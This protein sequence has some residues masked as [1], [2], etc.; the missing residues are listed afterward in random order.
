MKLRWI[1]LLALL[2]VIVKIELGIPDWLIVVS[3]LPTLFVILKVQEDR[4]WRRRTRHK[5]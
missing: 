1:A 3:L 5:R 4:E 2:G